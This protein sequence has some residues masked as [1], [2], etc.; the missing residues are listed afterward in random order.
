MPFRKKYRKPGN[1][2][3]AKKRYTKYKPKR[4]NRYRKVSVRQQTTLPTLVPD[5]SLLRF[6]YTYWNNFTT[7]TTGINALRFRGNS[8]YDPDQSG[9]GQTPYGFSFWEQIYKKYTVFSSCCKVEMTHVGTTESGCYAVII[10]YTDTT[11]TFDEITEA[12]QYPYA[13]Y[14]H[15]GQANGSSPRRVRHYM[16]TRRIW[17]VHKSATTSDEEYS[18]LVSAN[19]T[20]T[21][22][23]NIFFDSPDIAKACNLQV[24]IEIIYY[25][26]M[27]DRV[28]L[29][30]GSKKVKTPTTA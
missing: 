10:P 12:I 17:G 1:Y 7:S 26:E 16:T 22:Y 18:A 20:K 11:I 5:R 6:K 30:L 13:K 24:K 21:W 4:Y 2:S 27:Y 29:S 3:R 25:A 19:P 15:V 8:L 14:A 28:N 23:W 9:V